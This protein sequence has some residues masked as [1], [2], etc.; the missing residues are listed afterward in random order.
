[1]NMYSH[2]LIQI[3]IYAPILLIISYYLHINFCKWNETNPMSMCAEILMRLLWT[4]ADGSW[5][6][7]F[8]GQA[9]KCSTSASIC[10]TFLEKINVQ[11][12]FLFVV[13]YF[14][15]FEIQQNISKIDLCTEKQN[16]WT[17]CSPCTH[18]FKSILSRA[19]FSIDSVNFKLYSLWGVY[20]YSMYM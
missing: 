5:W 15:W 7:K 12:L 3:N 16:P 10:Y 4:R 20:E 18:T 9:S 19:T 14:F 6:P 11:F 1:M 2:L 17:Q 13:R 8:S